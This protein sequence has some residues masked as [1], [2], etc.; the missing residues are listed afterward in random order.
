MESD[1]QFGVDLENV[2]MAVRAG[3]ILGIAGVA[4]NGQTELMEALIGERPC[5]FARQIQLD[6]AD[7][8][9]AGPRERRA[10]GMCF[11]P[12]ERLASVVSC[13]GP[14]RILSGFIWNAGNEEQSAIPP[15]WPQL[16]LT[17][18][19]PGFRTGS[20]ISATYLLRRSEGPSGF[21]APPLRSRVMTKALTAERVRSDL[22]TMRPPPSALGANTPPLAGFC[23]DESTSQS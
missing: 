8:G 20:K 18:L 2:T 23:P 4:G 1:E 14:A 3:E 7:V 12:E 9:Q 17:L 15:S 10:L 5:R 16:G 22:K 11:A 21:A 6:G 19:F 13:H